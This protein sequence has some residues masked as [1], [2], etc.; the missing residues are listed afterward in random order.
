LER[1]E[2]A[3]ALQREVAAVLVLAHGEPQ[4]ALLLAGDRLGAYAPR[5]GLSSPQGRQQRDD[6]KVVLLLDTPE[7]LAVVQLWLDP[8][9]PLLLQLQ[10]L[11]SEDRGQELEDGQAHALAVHL[12]EHGTDRVRRSLGGELDHGQLIVLDGL[13]H[14]L[15][16]TA[17]ALAARV[18]ITVGLGVCPLPVVQLRGVQEDAQRE[19]RTSPVQSLN[20]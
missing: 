14:R 17:P 1:W 16:E 4:D 7:D 5:V 3:V 19:P 15:A 9:L 18:G 2:P 8:P 20:A 13:Q 11:G 6:L 12:L 10:S